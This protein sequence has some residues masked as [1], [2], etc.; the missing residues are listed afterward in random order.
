M[1]GCKDI[2]IGFFG[3]NT[4]ERAVNAEDYFMEKEEVRNICNAYI[5]NAERFRNCYFWDQDNGNSSTRKYR[6][7]QDSQ[8]DDFEYCGVRYSFNQTVT[9]ARKNTYFRSA[10]YVNDER[11]DL[12]AVKALLRKVSE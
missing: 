4:A 10:Y 1:C 3:L 5:S 8:H 11:K 6:D 7:R 9:R 2:Y 12:R